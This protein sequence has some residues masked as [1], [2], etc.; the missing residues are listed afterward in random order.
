[1]DIDLFDFDLPQHLIAQTPSLKRDESRLLAI[2]NDNKTY[3]DKIFHDI[4][5]YLRNDDFVN[6]MSSYAIELLLNKLSFRS[7]FN[8]LQKKNILDKINHLN[9]SVDNKDIVFI[10]GFLDSPSLIIKCDHSM[11]YNMLN[12]L[13]SDD[14]LYYIVLPYIT[15]NLSNNEIIT[16][17]L[18][19]DI[20]INELVNSDELLSKLKNSDI[21][22]Y[23]FRCRQNIIATIKNNK[24]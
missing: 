11:V 19:K 20:S 7:S 12:L 17:F 5:D 9:I 1:M 14:I 21:I 16:L 22:K 8:M 24:R 6:D 23:I 13:S 4:V 2:N 15:N 10:K 18:D 3:E